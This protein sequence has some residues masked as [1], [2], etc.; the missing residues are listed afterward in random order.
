[1]YYNLFLLL[2]M[3]NKLLK[4]YDIVPEINSDDIGGWHDI[5]NLNT[6]SSNRKLQ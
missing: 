2:I 5:S 1:M 6:I 3:H 4:T